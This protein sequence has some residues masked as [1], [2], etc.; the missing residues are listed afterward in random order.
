MKPTKWQIV[1]VIGHRVETGKL[2]LC[3]ISAADQTLLNSVLQVCVT[4]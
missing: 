2:L 3:R 4:C 1:A